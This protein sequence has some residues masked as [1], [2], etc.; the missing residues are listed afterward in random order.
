M[1]SINTIKGNAEDYGFLKGNTVTI[2]A[3]AVTLKA[4][5]LPKARVR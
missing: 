1:S 5:I 2:L 4:I 3:V